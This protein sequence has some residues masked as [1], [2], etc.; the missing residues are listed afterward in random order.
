MEEERK[1]WDPL[2]AFN[3]V[4]AQKNDRYTFKPWLLCETYKTLIPERYSS[5]RSQMQVDEFGQTWQLVNPFSVHEVNVGDFTK[6][7]Q[8]INLS[9]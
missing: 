2:E 9:G 3:N 7:T 4:R 6:E 5:Q 8:E 1:G